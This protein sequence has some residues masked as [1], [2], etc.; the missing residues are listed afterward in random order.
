MLFG[1]LAAQL[2]E[3]LQ[4]ANGLTPASEAIERQTEQFAGLDEVGNLADDR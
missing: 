3:C 4:L 1:A 2:D